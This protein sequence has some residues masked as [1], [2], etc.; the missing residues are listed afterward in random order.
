[1]NKNRFIFI[2]PLIAALALLAAFVLTA[3]VYAQDDIPP[4]NS[5]G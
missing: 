3:P 5:A 1:M 4:E 2:L